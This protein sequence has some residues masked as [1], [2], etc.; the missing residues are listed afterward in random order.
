LIFLEQETVVTNW[1]ISFQDVIS[2]RR[3]L[4]PF[5]EPT[6]ARQYPLLDQTVGNDINVIVKHENLNLTNA[7]KARNGLSMMTALSEEER[8]KGVISASRGN[9][10]Q[11]LALAGQLLDVPV[12]IC[13][14]VGNNSEK[15][16]AMRGY[17]AT[18]VEEGR[19]FDD[20]VDVSRRIEKEQGLRHVHAVNEPE[21]IAG[22]GTITLEILEQVTRL[23][24]MV[25]SV[26]GGSQAVGAMTVL[27]SLK[28]EVEVYAVQAEGASTIHDSWHAGKPIS[29][30][31]AETF[32]DGV[33]TRNTYELTFDA[34]RTGLKGFVAVSEAEI[35]E[36]LRLLLRTTHTLVEG[37]GAVGLAGLLRLRK[38]LAGK[39]VAIIISGGNIDAETLR[40][41][42]NN[43]I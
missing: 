16:D 7:F 22:A 21:I 40:R 5:L 11:G 14:P 28:P 35:A 23:D 27:R 17:G 26:G 39:T 3:R 38:E 34:L 37:A 24:A 15:N 30:D 32:A 42:L 2:A 4:R 8:G 19:D 6:P 10:G 20:A 13:V 25:I 18:V 33:A 43:E 12:T 9:H 31:K 29:K 1:P 41:V 36:A